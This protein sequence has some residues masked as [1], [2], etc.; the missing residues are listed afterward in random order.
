MLVKA[1]LNVNCEFGNIGDEV[2]VDKDII[3]RYWKDITLIEEIK[4]QWWNKPVK[5]AN[6]NK[7]KNEG[8]KRNYQNK[9]VKNARNK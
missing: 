7:N 9:P 5:N 4:E 6:D 1:K 3:R 8:N 2:V